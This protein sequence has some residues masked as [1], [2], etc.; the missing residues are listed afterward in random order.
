[1]VINQEDKIETRN[2]KTGA[3]VGNRWLV[4]EGL[5]AGDRVVVE[6]LQ[7]V[8]PGSPVRVV[9]W[10]ATPNDT[11]ATEQQVP[12]ES[13]EKAETTEQKEA[14]KTSG[15]APQATPQQQPASSPAKAE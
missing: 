7:K 5:Q 14:T 10:E 6:G 1:M 13:A 9:P 2:V 15:A 11:G 3:A 8:R 4:T 12:A